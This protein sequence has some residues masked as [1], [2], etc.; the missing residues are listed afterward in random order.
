MM[1]QGLLPHHYIS[2]SS[3]PGLTALIGLPPT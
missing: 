1:Q 2:E 3:L